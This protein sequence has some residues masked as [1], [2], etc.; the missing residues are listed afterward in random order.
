MIPIPLVFYRYGGKIRA[1]SSVIRQ[2][3]EDQA[4]N[5]SNRA[6]HLERE[7]KKRRE[8]E[9]RSKQDG[10][11]GGVLEATELDATEAVEH[12]PGMDPDMEKNAVTS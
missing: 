6:K 5:A 3:R 11:T 8:R 2:M 4:K 10:N 12:R 9:E 1:R 7:E